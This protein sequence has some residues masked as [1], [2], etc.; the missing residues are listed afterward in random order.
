MFSV[1]WLIRQDATSADPLFAVVSSQR[2]IYPNRKKKSNNISIYEI[3]KILRALWLAKN[4]L[5]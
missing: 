1:M 5:P 4:Y 3:N 2:Y